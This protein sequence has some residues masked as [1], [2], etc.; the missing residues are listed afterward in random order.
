MALQDMAPLPPFPDPIARPKWAFV[1][2]ERGLGLDEVAPI[3][4][5][6]REY[7][8]QLGLPWN[9]RKRVVPTPEEA[10][11]IEAWTGG[12]VTRADFEPPATPPADDQP[13]GG[14]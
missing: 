2:W 7:V 1:L 4:G 8:R 10:D 6:S 13:G 9:H 12:A 3:L 11:L 14:A 5:R